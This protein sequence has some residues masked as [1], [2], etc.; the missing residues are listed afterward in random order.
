M[1]ESVSERMRAVLDRLRAKPEEAFLLTEA[2]RTEPD[3]LDNI[4]EVLHSKAAEEPR[5]YTPEQAAEAILWR[6][7]N[8]VRATAVTRGLERAEI[9]RQVFRKLTLASLRLR[10]HPNE[11]V[12]DVR[13]VA[14][15]Y[16]TSQM[17]K[18]S[19]CD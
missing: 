18:G 6:V 1:S 13:D 12:E 5:R 8:L 14:S 15:Q 9:H 2:M 19:G 3:E 11:L 4:S 17:Y 16:K 10:D 7:E